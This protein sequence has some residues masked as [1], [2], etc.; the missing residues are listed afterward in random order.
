MSSTLFQ[1]KSSPT[2]LQAQESRP[3][4]EKDGKGRDE[5][6]VNGHS[7]AVKDLAERGT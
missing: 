4:S 6:D 2:A 1:K 7:A 5:R 3:E